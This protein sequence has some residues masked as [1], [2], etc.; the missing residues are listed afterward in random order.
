[1]K[2]FAYSRAETVEAAVGL[3]TTQANSKFLGGGT[4]LV[5]LMREN[6]E[7]PDA[8]IFQGPT[9]GRG[10]DLRVTIERRYSPRVLFEV[11]GPQGKLVGVVEARD[12]PSFAI[13]ARTLVRCCK[14]S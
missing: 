10:P 8:L 2:N 14:S 12:A 7:Q 11:T 4:N 1:M 5:D 6:I 3:I 13:A 9:S